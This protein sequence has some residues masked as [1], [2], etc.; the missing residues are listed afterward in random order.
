MTLSIHVR[1]DDAV[2]VYDDGDPRSGIVLEKVTDIAKVIADLSSTAIRLHG[3][4]AWRRA[5]MRVCIEA[6]A[7]DDFPKDLN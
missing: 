7:E 3:D 5:K 6:V 2:I 4:A 1:S